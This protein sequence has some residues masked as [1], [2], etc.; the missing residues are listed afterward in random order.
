MIYPLTPQAKAEW[1]P[2]QTTL[3]LKQLSPGWRGWLAFQQE[4]GAAAVV[5]V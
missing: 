4:Q 5:L 2:H 3:N 1:T